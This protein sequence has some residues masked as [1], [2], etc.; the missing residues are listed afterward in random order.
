MSLPE[1]LSDIIKGE[2]V[3][4]IGKPKLAPFI[5]KRLLGT[6]PFLAFM[7]FPLFIF[8]FGGIWSTPATFFIM[9]FLAFW[10]GTLLLVFS[11][12]TVYPLLVWRNIYYVLTD[13]KL[14]VRRGVIGIDFDI[15]KLELVQQVNVNVGVIDKIYGTGSIIVQA[16][17]VQPLVIE[18]VEN[19]LKVR[20]VID[21]QLI[22][23]SERLG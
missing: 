5:L 23:I 14:I 9:L 3:I 8:R 20:E 11:S 13:R 7:L 1:D 19:P 18:N 17:G 6:V 21:E 15:L 12:L 2:K 10:Y 22:E 4:W 16:V